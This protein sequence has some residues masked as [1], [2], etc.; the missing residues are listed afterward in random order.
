MS[1]WPAIMVLGASGLIGEALAG[2]LMG[3]G[4]KVTAVARGFTPSQRDLFGAERIER[5]FVGLSP[6][7]LAQ[8]LSEREVQILINCVGVL[9]DGPGGETDTVHRAFTEDLLSALS[10]L[11]RPVLFIQIS[12]PGASPSDQTAFAR[13]KRA[14]EQAIS[15]AGTPFVI[16][17]PGLVIAPCAFGGSAL[18]RALSVL[19]F[20]LPAR[21]AAASIAITAVEDILRTAVFVARKWADGERQWRVTWDVMARQPVLMAE[22]IAAFRRRL[23]GPSPQL[24]LP[25]FLLSAGARAGDLAAWAGWRPPIRST[26]LIEMRRGVMGDPQPWITATGIAPR[27]LEAAVLGLPASVQEKWFARLYLLKALIIASLAVFFAASGL[28]ALTVSFDAAAAILVLHG[29]PASLANAVTVI[30]SVADIC[31][32]IAIALRRSCRLGLIAGIA[33]SSLYL[34]SAILVAPELWLEPLGALVK[35]LPAIVLML[36]ALAVLDER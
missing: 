18:I 7:A 32:G 30:T 27:S 9:Q 34:A 21:E 31:V 10:L 29:W 3:E 11:N 25:P 20:A 14:A 36:V 8:M 17:R 35:T 28:I 2:G 12:I 15:R 4:F 23:G 13:T 6:A 26:A 33:L 22:L 16:L 24:T 1:G 19:P 5:S